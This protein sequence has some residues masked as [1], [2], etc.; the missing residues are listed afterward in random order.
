MPI[1]RSSIKME[2]KCH[3]LSSSYTL[4][5]N[6]TLPSSWYFAEC[7]ISW[8]SAKQYFAECSTRQNFAL[9][10][11]GFAECQSQALGKSGLCRGLS[12]ARQNLA[13]PW[14]RPPTV[15][16]CRVPAI[17]HSTKF[18]FIFLKKKLC[19]VS[20]LSTRQKKNLF[21]ENKFCRVPPGPGTRQRHFCRVLPMALGKIYL[22]F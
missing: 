9:G 22:F 12:G 21:S 15:R 10:K 1:D 5:E 20:S 13:G 18:V 4:L 16:F 3:N 17:R 11:A 19:R 2:Q 6:Y 14:R 7:K 8:H